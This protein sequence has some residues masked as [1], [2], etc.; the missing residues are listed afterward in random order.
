MRKLRHMDDFTN[1]IGLHKS[2]FNAAEQ[3]FLHALVQQGNASFLADFEDLGSHDALKKALVQ[4]LLRFSE[5]YSG[6]HEAG[7]P[8]KKG[9]DWGL[10]IYLNEIRRQL[11]KLQEKL[12]KDVAKPKKGASAMVAAAPIYSLDKHSLEEHASLEKKAILQLHRVSFVLVAGGLGERLGLGSSSIKLAQAFNPYT[13]QSFLEYFSKLVKGLKNLYRQATGKTIEIPFIIMVSPSTK[14][15]LLELLDKQKNFSFEKNEIQLAEQ[16]LVPCLKNWKADLA[17][18]PSYVLEEKPCGH[19]Y[20]HRLFFKQ[21]LA[22]TLLDEG[23]D[24]LISLQ[25]TNLQIASSLL[26]SLALAIESPADFFMLGTT[27]YRYEKLGV[28]TT[29]AKPLHQL[30]KAEKI[31]FLQNKEYNQLSEQEELEF[32]LLETKNGKNT[33]P[34]DASLQASRNFPANLN[35]FIYKVPSYMKKLQSI[36]G[37]LAFSVNPK[38]NQDKTVFEKHLRPESFMQ[39]I[40]CLY[41]NTFAKDARGKESGAKESGARPHSS[42]VIYLKR[43]FSFSALKD[44]FKEQLKNKKLT[45]F[46]GSK[47]D[48]LYYKAIRKKLL[49]YCQCVFPSD[50]AKIIDRQEE[51]Q[52]ADGSRLSEKARISIPMGWLLSLDELKARVKNCSFGDGSLLQLEG[53]IVVDS[54]HLGRQSALCIKAE[55]GVQLKVEHI[56]IHNE[57]LRL[58]AIAEVDILNPPKIFAQQQSI[59]KEAKHAKGNEEQKKLSENEW[60]RGYKVIHQK[61]QALSEFVFHITKPGRYQLKQ[62]TDTGLEITLQERC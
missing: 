3:L 10:N 50:D 59:F 40:S 52:L 13:L 1:I 55:E 25:D 27:R 12:A 51:L 4:K 37:S 41:E 9:Q 31:F 26:A 61:K 62:N 45:M 30:A 42:A 54:I 14:P 53:D 18:S 21:S 34:A 23:K 58:Q 47:M 39:D 28:L 44:S 8:P 2:I 56:K 43:I 60:I 6:H 48:E 32:Q 15:A 17:L 33:R 36:K 19:G 11:Q 38:L 46:T 24:L 16:P 20:I 49:G 7:H 57:G 5:A 35:C 22:A 29:A